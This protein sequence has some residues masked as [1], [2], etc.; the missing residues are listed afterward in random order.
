MTLLI[1]LVQVKPT[2]KLMDFTVLEVSRCSSVV[3]DIR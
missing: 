3:L 1:L 2:D